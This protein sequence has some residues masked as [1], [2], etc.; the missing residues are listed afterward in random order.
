DADPLRAQRVDGAPA[1]AYLGGHVPLGFDAALAAA[2]IRFA[3]ERT[4]FGTLYTAFELTPDRYR[5]VSPAGWTA[6][7]SLH[8]E[9]APWALDREAAT[10]WRSGERRRAGLWFQVDLSRVHPIGMVS[11]LPAAFQEVPTGFRVETSLDGASWSP[12]REASP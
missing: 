5:E 4:P 9:T 1:V 3:R 12:A 11:W 6:T 2:G 8:P 10:E 7:A